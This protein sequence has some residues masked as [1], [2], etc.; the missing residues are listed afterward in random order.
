MPSLC[1]YSLALLLSF[2]HPIL[3]AETAPSN[4]FGLGRLVDVGE[5]AVWDRDV[6]PDGQ[7]LP[8]GRG[9]VQQGAQ[10]YRQK[11]AACHGENGVEGPFDVLVGRLPDDARE[12][13]QGAL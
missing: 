9:S 11:C 8:E 2:A 12:G 13:E 7:G 6:R 3:V 1:R 10:T 4:S 5:I